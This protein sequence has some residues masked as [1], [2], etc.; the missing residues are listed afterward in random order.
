MTDAAIAQQVLDGPWQYAAAARKACRDEAWPAFVREAAPARP[1]L[2]GRGDHARCIALAESAPTGPVMAR[3]ELV[4]LWGCVTDE[5][6]SSEWL[7]VHAVRWRGEAMVVQESTPF[8]EDASPRVDALWECEVR[9]WTAGVVVTSDAYG[10]SVPMR[11]RAGALAVLELQ[12]VEVLSVA[13]HEAARVA[14]PVAEVPLFSRRFLPRVAL[15]SEL[16]QAI[17]ALCFT[18]SDGDD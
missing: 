14:R 9:R 8:L 13:V 6:P 5:T 3:L 18:A 17:D 1:V 16:G 4:P 11:L 12:V 10:P 15:A 2:F 7:A